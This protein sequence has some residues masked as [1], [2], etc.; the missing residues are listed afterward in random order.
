[1][2]IAAGICDTLGVTGYHTAVPYTP[3][4]FILNEMIGELKAESLLEDKE[5]KLVDAGILLEQKE[6]PINILEKSHAALVRNMN[7]HAKIPEN[8]INEPC[9]EIPVEVCDGNDYIPVNTA[10]Y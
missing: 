1:M 6:D 2:L 5:N 4:R 8:A 10:T 7:K 3:S 9:E